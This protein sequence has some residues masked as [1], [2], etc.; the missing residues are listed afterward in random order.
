MSI[1]KDIRCDANMAEDCAD[2]VNAG[3]KGFESVAALRAIGRK[4]GWTY[5]SGVGDVCPAC[6]KEP[7]P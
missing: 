2:R 6:R 7:T 3:P 4:V 1:W 5:W